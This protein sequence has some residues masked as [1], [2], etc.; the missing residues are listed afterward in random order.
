MKTNQPF[1][2]F[3][4]TKVLIALG[5]SSLST[6]TF[7]QTCSE[8]STSL[9][10][11]QAKQYNLMSGEGDDAKRLIELEKDHDATLS[12]LTII[13][14]LHKLN[15]EYFKTLKRDAIPIS[16]N[17][18]DDVLSIINSVSSDDLTDK[19][20]QRK[21]KHLSVLENMA[22]MDSLLSEMRNADNVNESLFR[23]SSIPE[24]SS[25]TQEV[26]GKV[27]QI[28]ASC[29]ASTSTNRSNLCKSLTQEKSD[30]ARELVKGFITAFTADQTSRATPESRKQTLDN[31]HA[32]LRN[33]LDPSSDL[34]QLFQDAKAVAATSES[35]Q[36]IARV[37]SYAN[38]STV[39]G[40]VTTVTKNENIKNLEYA[41]C[42][43]LSNIRANQR[44][45][46]KEG[47]GFQN[48][49]VSCDSYT[50]KV[51]NSLKDVLE[52]FVNYESRV[53]SSLNYDFD[54]VNPESLM[55]KESLRAQ[56]TIFNQN[57][58]LSTYVQTVTGGLS[59]LGTG[60][61]SSNIS[62]SF[63]EL[64]EGSTKIDSTVKSLMA[65]LGVIFRRGKINAPDGRNFPTGK[66]FL[67][68]GIE[69][70]DRPRIT[71][72]VNKRICDI[73]KK[74][75]Q[76]KQCDNTEYVTVGANGFELKDNDELLSVFGN[77]AE[78]H[79]IWEDEQKLY[80]DKLADIKA[81]I[82]ALKAKPEY[83]H[84]EQI[85]NFM[86]LDF[87]AR[88]NYKTEDNDI[89]ISG[90]NADLDG[91]P[92]IDYLVADVNGISNALL[93]E[94]D[95]NKI[96]NYNLANASL[97]QRRT[98]L[99]N[100]NGACQGLTRLN[101]EKP[102]Q[103]FSSP[104]I[105]AVCGR[106]VSMN[107]EA[108]ITTAYERGQR[109][110]SR[111][112]RLTGDGNYKKKKSTGSQIGLGVLQGLGNSAGTL[113]GTFAQGRILN[114]S[115]PYQER[116]IYNQMDQQYAYN[117]YQQNAQPNYFY[118]GMNNPYYLPQFGGYSGGYNFN[119]TG[120]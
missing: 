25:F 70:Q 38:S 73:A 67:S 60:N 104:A 16:E 91:N 50:N 100:M 94:Y 78:L 65:R 64:T 71:S 72:E 29:V 39:S 51:P 113:V 18:F 10:S 102:N 66:A 14:E 19:E 116:Y 81:K 49:R 33:G 111:G 54:R 69:E 99:G 36:I 45:A 61:A 87:Q 1:K 55:D 52:T 79:R 9:N 63:S 117:W 75:D 93:A 7:S 23:V 47:S 68:S 82:N 40:G 120:L 12:Q 107:T 56:K 13:H 109:I 59:F 89:K 32:I 119:A 96:Q 4:H 80:Q 48:D 15:D 110:E 103:G 21:I 97:Q 11:I 27:N 92:A 3:I 76:S 24:G 44:D 28:I 37:R 77:G 101:T 58:A 20:T 88:C 26:E 30:S 115:L 41:Y 86:V 42:C 62:N 108:S 46:C 31:Y 34:F 6:F 17:G 105:T 83:A 43:T 114:D 22:T 35:S 85:K 2:K 106:V 98:I 57:N 8:L 118:P 74:I 84:L 90:C 95:P 112:Y 53:Y 5:L